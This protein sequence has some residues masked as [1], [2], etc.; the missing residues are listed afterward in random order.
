MLALSESR[1]AMYADEMDGSHEFKFCTPAEERRAVA[2]GCHTLPVSPP[3]PA[4]DADG[5]PD[6][7]AARRI[8]RTWST[9]LDVA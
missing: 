9:L 7:T 1:A 2:D 4:P 6:A 3:L 5:R 8:R